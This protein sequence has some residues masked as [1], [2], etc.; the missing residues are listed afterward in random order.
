MSALALIAQSTSFSVVMIN[1][2]LRNVFITLL[3]YSK[4]GK[5]SNLANATMYSVL[6]VSFFNYG[7]LYIIAPWNY[8]D[9]KGSFFS[10]VYSDYTS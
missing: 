10:G 3:S 8:S 7:I 2:I 5:Y 9:Q 1:F 4:L 6:L